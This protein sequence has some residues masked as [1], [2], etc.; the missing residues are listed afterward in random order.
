MDD[1]RVLTLCQPWASL[2]ALG[3]K[4]VET[5]GPRFPRKWRGTL[6]IHA[7]STLPA[8]VMGTS[9]GGMRG[10]REK[11]LADPF[12]DALRCLTPGS[13]GFTGGHGVPLADGTTQ[14]VRDLYP[15]Q[16]PLG[17]IVAVC[18]LVAVVPAESL[19]LR[20]LGRER[21]F[22]DYSPG[23]C[24]LMLEDVRRLERPVAYV[25][26]QGLRR[27]DR[28]QVECSSGYCGWDP[29]SGDTH[30]CPRKAGQL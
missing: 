2:V 1:V 28:S 11:A 6:V 4:T 8:R 9:V 21:A 23:R 3:A 17:Q 16:V 25:N 30:T 12:Y 19:D 10:L 27:L 22:G 20:R 26:G 29:I 5:R 18:Q 7:G 13:G 24:A 14:H 15:L